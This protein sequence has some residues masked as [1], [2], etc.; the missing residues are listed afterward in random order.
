LWLPAGVNNPPASTTKTNNEA[1]TY[2]PRLFITRP[3]DDFLPAHFF[4]AGFDH[5]DCDAL[6]LP[7]IIIE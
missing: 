7:K 2:A 3:F 5:D 6:L 1:R 4:G